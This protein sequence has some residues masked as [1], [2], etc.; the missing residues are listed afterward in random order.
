MAELVVQIAGTGGNVRAVRWRAR[1]LLGLALLSPLL[2]FL[3]A[4]TYWPTVQVLWQS[5]HAGSRTASVFGLDNYRALVADPS[6]RHALLN[7]V[8]Y[9]VGTIVPSLVLALAFALTLVH[10]TRFNAQRH[11]IPGIQP[12]PDHFVSLLKQLPRHVDRVAHSIE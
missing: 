12:Q 1:N 4:F 5:L 2:V 7:N 10:S 3:T 6:F 11:A 8:A 9:A